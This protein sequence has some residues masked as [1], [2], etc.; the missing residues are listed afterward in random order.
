MLLNPHKFQSAVSVCP[1]YCSLM[2][3]VTSH[4]HTGYPG[5]G[6]VGVSGSGTGR[7]FE[8]EMLH[9]QLSANLHAMLQGL[10]VLNTNVLVSLQYVTPIVMCWSANKLFSCLNSALHGIPARVVSV[11]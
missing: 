8:A 2:F 10:H 1:D 5:M 11:T 6:D 7:V 4:I 3:Q 9:Y